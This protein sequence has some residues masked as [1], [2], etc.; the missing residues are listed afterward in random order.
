[1]I[2]HEQYRLA[3]KLLNAARRY[4]SDTADEFAAISRYQAAR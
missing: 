1:M 2:R 4:S 3:M